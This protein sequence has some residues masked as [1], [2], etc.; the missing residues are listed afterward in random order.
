VAVRHGG[1]SW[2]ERARACS[3][4][5][6]LS[7]R[8]H[9]GAAWLFSATYGGGLVDGDRIAM[10]AEVRAGAALLLATQ[11]S[12]KVYRSPRGCAQA[13]DATVDEG[14]LLVAWPDP[15]V[16]YAG[17]RYRQESRVAL[18][19][20]ASALVVDSFTAGRSARG[21]R[22]AFASLASRLEVSV[23]GAPLV[24]DALLL[25]PQQGPLLARM[26]RF[27]AFATIVAVGPR[28][29]AIAAALL[30]GAPALGRQAELLVA[31]SPLAGGAIVRIAAIS[32][33]RAGRAVRALLAGVPA[34]LGD[35]PWR[36][37]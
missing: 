7:P 21:E 29:E 36:G 18:A 13:L 28:L 14:G 11:A 16:C 10:R 19:G 17:A 9:G 12:T 33:E 34:L 1:R 5:K 31:A 8:N 3:P 6:L 22:W 30:A 15:V 27:D 20:G 37:R 26:G 24:R 25:D 2:L 35:D 23:G 4:L 32:V